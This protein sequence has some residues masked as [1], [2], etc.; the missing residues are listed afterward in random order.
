MRKIRRAARILV[1]V[2][3]VLAVLYL[4][5]AIHYWLGWPDWLRNY[6]GIGFV[7]IMIAVWFAPVRKVATRRMAAI[8]CLAA[9]TTAYLAKSPVEQDWVPL[10]ERKVHALVVGDS[11]RIENFRDAI[12]RIGEP[13]MPRWTQID[14]DLSTLRSAELILQPFGDFK[15]MEHAMLS[16]GFADGRHVVVSMEARRTSWEHFDWLAGFFRHDQ[17]YPVIGTE[18]DLIWKRLARDPPFRIQFYPIRRDR[19]AVRAY[20]ERVLEF[21][22]AVDDKPQ[23]YNTIRESCLTTLLRL[24]PETFADVPW[25]DLRRWLPGYSLSL[26]RDLGLVDDSLSAEQLAARRTLRSGI[27]SPADFPGDPAWS[28]YLREQWPALTETRLDV[29]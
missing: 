26:F 28:A 21:A 8:A 7:L 12:H 6:G 22:N 5:L 14:L 18:R 3:F 9:L 24:A 13:A 23:F 29:D 15:V 27:R 25:Y 17:I 2:I 20:F 11:V 1:N 16:F 19:R 10:H 4:G